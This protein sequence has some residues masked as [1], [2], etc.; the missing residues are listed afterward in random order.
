MFLI[1]F[2]VNTFK[3]QGKKKKWDEQHMDQAV[4][5]VKKDGVQLRKAARIMGVP[6]WSLRN[7]INLGSCWLLFSK[8][9]YN[10]NKNEIRLKNANFKYTSG[11]LEPC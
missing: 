9:D 2:R 6:R 1:D 8:K 4:E 5:L 3:E 11:K 10:C 7:R